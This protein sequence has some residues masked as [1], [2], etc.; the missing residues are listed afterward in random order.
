MASE[1]HDEAS[2]TAA[3][4]NDL[5]RWLEERAAA[6]GLDQGEFLR[7]L[8]AAHSAADEG[9]PEDHE[10]PPAVAAAIDDQREEFEELL[11][12]VRKR[13]VQV[14]RET[15]RKAAEDHDHP[16]LESRV[17]DVDERVAA[18][19]EQAADLD[20]ALS[21]VDVELTDL[22][23]TVAELSAD[24]DAGFENYRD[25]LTS[26]TEATETVEDR[27]DVLARAVLDAREELRRQA[28]RES[29]RREA[30]RLQLAANREGVSAADCAECGSEV[31]IGL[32]STPECPHC[33]STFTDVEG[34]RGFFTSATLATGDPPA[35]EGAVGGEMDD[36]L[37]G[38]VEDLE[39]AT[40]TD[41]TAP[42][43]ETG[44]RQ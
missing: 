42:P 13:V 21:A 18:V 2:V 36:S 38:M 5:D 29:A 16:E 28:A 1:E 11:A 43:D 26:L 8:L 40:P 7:R 34:K 6:A 22:E 39:D 33:A 12:D 17:E 32:L 31:Q 4:P 37:D 24:L 27:L 30:E 23:E 9:D 14:K 41:V 15:D 3:L 25:V 44:E 35:L 10:L 19:D 20:A